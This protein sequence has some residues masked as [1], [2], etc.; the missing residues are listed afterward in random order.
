MNKKTKIIS[1]IIIVLLCVCV[2]NIS[3]SY[4]NDTFYLIKLGES[5]SK[6]GL[7]MKD[8]F[9]W[10]ISLPYT[11]PHWLYSIFLF[12]IY[13]NFGFLGIYL[14]C[15]IVFIVLSLIIYYVNIKINKSN[16]LALIV[17]FVSVMSLSLF[18]VPRSQSISIIFLFLEVYFI[19]NLI[20]TG[21]VKYSIYLIICSLII[22]NVHATIWIVFFIFFMPFLGEQIVY[23]FNKKK[24][25]TFNHL[26]INKINNIKLLLVTFIICL[27]MGLFTPSRICYTYFFKIFLGNSQNY[28]SEHYNLQILKYPLLIVLCGLFFFNKSKIK[29]SELLMIGGIVLMTIISQRHII[30]FSTIGILYFSIVLKRNIDDKKDQTFN[31]LE[32][33]INKW[34]GIPMFLIVSL[35]IFCY[36]NVSSN[37]KGGF[38]DKEV[39]P[40]DAVNYIK[41]NLDYQDMKI[42]NNYDFGSFLLFNDIKVFVD[43]RCD[44]YLKEFNGQNKSILDD[45]YDLFN[46]QMITKYD[47][48]LSKYGADYFLIYKKDFLYYFLT[49]DNNYHL[50]YED[51]FFVLYQKEGGKSEKEI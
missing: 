31:I 34:W 39:Y 32:N 33:R 46:T 2:C 22:A 13:D 8:H 11:Y 25:I 51:N 43:S 20:N 29:L 14:S 48:Y 40:V 45:Y 49:R 35:S 41:N 28:I 47:D 21:K 17:S 42:I 18:M 27:L 5:I 19:N 12:F 26:T 1:I 24:K 50:V 38:I 30:F 3:L 10:I 9:S 16:L 36:F 6:Y 37:I 15:I 44:L 4:N 23:L 7:D